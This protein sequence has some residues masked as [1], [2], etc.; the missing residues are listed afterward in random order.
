MDVVAKGRKFTTS[1]VDILPSEVL[2]T[3]LSFV[4][5]SSPADLSRCKLSCKTLR[6]I[7]EEKGVLQQIHLR[8]IK[9]RMFCPHR[10][11]VEKFFMTCVENEHLEAM[12]DFGF[13]QYFN[14]LV[15]DEGLT[16]LERATELHNSMAEYVVSLIY[17]YTGEEERGVKLL[18]NTI[19]SVGSE[20]IVQCRREL[21]QMAMSNWMRNHMIVH[22]MPQPKL[23]C[24]KKTTAREE[25]KPMGSSL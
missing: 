10:E 8:W 15:L 1:M 22:Y 9:T 20:G 21:R 11:A 12:L 5:K 6:R 2:A 3:I 24:K 23:F 4:A 16:M 18:E 14:T 13:R 7:A 25:L 17:I 19:N